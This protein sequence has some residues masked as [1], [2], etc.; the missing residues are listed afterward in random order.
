MWIQVELGSMIKMQACQNETELAV[1]KVPSIENNVHLLGC[2]V[3]ETPL[4]I[5]KF[6]F[7]VRETNSRAVS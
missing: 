3:P 4:V 1:W 5:G 7:P 2:R 6:T